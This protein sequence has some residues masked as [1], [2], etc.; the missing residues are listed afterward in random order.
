MSHEGQAQE[1]AI[2]PRKASKIFHRHNIAMSLLPV[3]PQEGPLESSDLLG[4]VFGYI[5]RGESCFTRVNAQWIDIY[6]KLFGAKTTY[7]AVLAS[8]ARVEVAA[9]E[10][11]RLT[12]KLFT[13]AAWTGNL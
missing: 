3:Q 10:G 11:C 12:R 7:D 8:E 1:L 13:K 6:V 4:E 2:I 9:A 5:G